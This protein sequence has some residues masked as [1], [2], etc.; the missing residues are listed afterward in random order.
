LLRQLVQGQQA[1]QKF[2]QQ[3]GGHNVHQ[4]QAASYLD[5][6]DTQP[7][8]FHKTEVSDPGLRDCVHNIV[9]TGLEDRTCPIPYL[10]C[11]LLACEVGWSVPPI[12]EDL[13][14]SIYQFQEAN[15]TFITSDGTSPYNSTRGLQLKPTLIH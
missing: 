14:V 4:P 9:H 2:Q 13:K 5:F 7:P 3:W 11:T 12:R 1:F 10:C 15:N 8:L 6:L